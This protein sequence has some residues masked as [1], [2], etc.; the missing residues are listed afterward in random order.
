MYMREMWHKLVHS[1]VV[2]ATA[3][4]LPVFI[5]KINDQ[6]LELKNIKCPIFVENLAKTISRC[7][8]EYK[9][10]LNS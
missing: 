9:N 1:I 7:P 3:I 10:D 2:Q 8:L 6:N 4:K 5:R